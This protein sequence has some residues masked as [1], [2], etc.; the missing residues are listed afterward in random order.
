MKYVFGAV[1]VGAIAYLVARRKGAVPEVP[2]PG[3]AVKVV[4]DVK[5]AAASAADDAKAAAKDAG[6]KAKKAVQDATS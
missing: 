1:V 6:K 4:D 3:A 2:V 5:A